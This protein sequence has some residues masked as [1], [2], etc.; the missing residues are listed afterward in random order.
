MNKDYATNPLWMLCQ[1]NLKRM[2]LLRDSLDV[3]KTVDTNDELDT[4]ELLL[5]GCDALHDLR[6][7]EAFIKLLR[8]DADGECTD[9]DNFTLEFDCIRSSRQ[10]SVILL[11]NEPML[12]ISGSYNILAQLLRK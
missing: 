4:L 6:L 7:F 5:E 12:E 2:Q 8:V 3:V 10:S 11:V 1:E 9:C